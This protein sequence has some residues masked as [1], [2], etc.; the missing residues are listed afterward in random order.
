MKKERFMYIIVGE[1]EE[2]SSIKEVQDYVKENLG[3]TYKK[4]NMDGK[5]HTV[6]KIVETFDQVEFTDTLQ[7]TGLKLLKVYDQRPEGANFYTNCFIGGNLGLTLEEIEELK[8]K[9]NKGLKRDDRW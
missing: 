6:K 9:E 2:G 3:E 1:I 8:K 4:D 7:E 5:K